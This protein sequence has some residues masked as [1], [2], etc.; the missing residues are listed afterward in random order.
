MEE[1]IAKTFL[2]SCN[3]GNED[4]LKVLLD[5]N[6][7]QD[8]NETHNGNKQNGLIIACI[9]GH[10]NI[11]NLI[12]NASKKIDINAQDNSGHTALSYA[13]YF[14]NIRPLSV[15]KELV[16]AII[17]N[18]TIDDIK[19]YNNLKHN[20]GFP[21][22]VFSVQN[23]EIMQLFIEAGFDINLQ[24]LKCGKNSLMYAC[25]YNHVE[26]VKVLLD[27]GANINAVSKEGATALMYASKN[28]HVECVKLLLSAHPPPDI[29]IKS[30]KFNDTALT[31]SKQ[32]GHVYITELLQKYEND[33]KLF[34]TMQELNSIK[35]E[36]NVLL[37]KLNALH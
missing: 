21:L 1:V 37:Y 34:K 18:M 27:S 14:N 33:M 31:I 13:S 29:T 22:I 19:T 11:A 16:S 15:N 10:V 5:N 24:T 6:L 2:Q 8:I 32:Y 17:S 28:G 35:S 26:S 30:F 4:T 12:L 23:E 25:G 20:N 7:V 36:L 9:N 3:D